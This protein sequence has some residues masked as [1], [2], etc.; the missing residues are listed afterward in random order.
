MYTHIHSYFFVPP[1]CI[2]L[3][4]LTIAAIR[5]LVLFAAVEAA[6]DTITF[7]N[8]SSYSSAKFNSTKRAVSERMEDKNCGIGRVEPYIRCHDRCGQHRVA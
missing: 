1:L 7:R 4:K 8:G 2:R 6:V 3:A 5:R